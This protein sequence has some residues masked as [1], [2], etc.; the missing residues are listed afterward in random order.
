MTAR[1]EGWMAMPARI[2]A[3][4]REI[5][6]VA[7]L[8]QPMRESGR[9]VMRKG[10]APVLFAV[11][12]DIAGEV[13]LYGTLGE[14]PFAAGALEPV[15]VAPAGDRLQRKIPCRL[16]HGVIGPR[17]P[18]SR[19]VIDFEDDVRGDMTGARRAV[20][21]NLERFPAEFRDRVLSR[22]T[23]RVPSLKSQR[24]SKA[25]RPSKSPSSTRKA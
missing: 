2:E 6:Q 19:V 18:R 3:K 5:R 13:G 1:S 24:S 25:P 15:A 10:D 11:M 20:L 9:P 12:T 17:L 7:E 14:R 22:R 16:K 4:Y 21:E 8:S 23:G